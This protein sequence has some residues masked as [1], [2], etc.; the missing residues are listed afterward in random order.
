MTQRRLFLAAAASFVLAAPALAQPAEPSQTPPPATAPSEA[1]SAPAPAG[2]TPIAPSGDILSTLDASGE[3]KTFVAAAKATNLAQIFKAQPN[4]T[5]LAPTDAAFAAM[6]QDQLQSL[7]QRANVGQLQRLV[8]YH[9]I[10]ARIDPSQIEGHAASPVPTV[11][12]AAVVLNGLA[13]PMKANGADIVQPGV[14]ATNGVIYVV[15]Q[16]LSP[17]TAPPVPPPPAPDAPPAS[18]AAP[19]PPSGG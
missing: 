1:P 3:F 17:E 11:A 19:A 13:Q 6:P 10:N 15:D 9:L 7:M 18:D 14:V 12:G 2:Y 16:V 4:I 8:M 5:V